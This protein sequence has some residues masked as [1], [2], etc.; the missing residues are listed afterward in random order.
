MAG[1]LAAGLAFMGGIGGGPVG[2][3]TRLGRGCLC[4][5][6]V[7]VPGDRVKCWTPS[8]KRVTSASVVA[9][10]VIQR[11]RFCEPSQVQKNDQFWSGSMA[12]EGRCAKTL[13][14]CGAR[15]ISTC[16][17]VESVRGVHG[18]GDLCKGALCDGAGRQAAVADDRA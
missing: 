12:C 17:V 16:G 3:R 4:S 1:G 7:L 15:R 2:D 13:L 9:K 11:T 5:D 14:A 8:A 18:G 10:L 6:V